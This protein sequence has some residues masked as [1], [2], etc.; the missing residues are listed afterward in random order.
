MTRESIDVLKFQISHLYTIG[1]DIFWRVLFVD[2]E[3]LPLHWLATRLHMSGQKPAWFGSCI[4]NFEIG[5]WALKK[6]EI[7]IKYAPTLSL[8]HSRTKFSK[9]FLEGVHPY[10]APPQTS[11]ATLICKTLTQ[12]GLFTQCVFIR[13]AVYHGSMATLWPDKNQTKTTGQV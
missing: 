3:E 12:V 6:F 1:V 8:Q 5:V 9:M 10:Q 2:K 7:Y 11:P 13:E 4:E